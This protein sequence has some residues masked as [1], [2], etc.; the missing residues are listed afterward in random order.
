[1]RRHKMSRRGSKRSFSRNAGTRKINVR[2]GAKRGG[3]R[4]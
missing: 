4:L 3:Y 2:A 1:M